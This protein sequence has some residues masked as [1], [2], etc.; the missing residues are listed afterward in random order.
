MTQETF[1][2]VH[3]TTVLHQLGDPV[4]EPPERRRPDWSEIVRD[5]GGRAVV[6]EHPRGARVAIEK[7]QGQ[8]VVETQGS[9]AGIGERHRQALGFYCS[10]RVEQPFY[11][12]IGVRTCGGGMQRR[13]TE[14]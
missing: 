2:E 4:V 7:R 10:T 14:D 8:R 3:R 6:Q 12:S 11:A 1:V 9:R 13:P 5:A